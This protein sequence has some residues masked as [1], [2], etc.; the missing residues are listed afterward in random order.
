MI[1]KYLTYLNIFPAL[2]GFNFTRYLN[3]HSI[4]HTRS[5]EQFLGR[6][7]LKQLTDTTAFVDNTG[8]IDSFNLIQCMKI[9][10]VTVVRYPT[11]VVQ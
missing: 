5:L 4:T 11:T 1:S 10:M 6:E 8:F 7:I 9:Q 3:P 2:S